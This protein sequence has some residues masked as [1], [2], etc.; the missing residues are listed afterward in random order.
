[1]QGKSEFVNLKV[2]ESTRAD[3][4]IIA[5]LSNEKQQDAIKRI[6]E[7]EKARILAK[8]SK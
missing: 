2:Y 8:Q 5:A 6:V 1:M 7:E 3:L 4:K